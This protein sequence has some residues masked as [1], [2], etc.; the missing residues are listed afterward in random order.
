[1]SFGEVDDIDSVTDAKC[2]QINDRLA[3]KIGLQNQ[4]EDY[5]DGMLLD[6]NPS[7]YSKLEKLSNHNEFQE[8]VY[9]ETLNSIHH[10][11]FGDGKPRDSHQTTDS[12]LRKKDLG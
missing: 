8:P 7:D 11:T 12:T 6:S 2:G 10:H 9:N 4:N 3:G 1:M 5:Q